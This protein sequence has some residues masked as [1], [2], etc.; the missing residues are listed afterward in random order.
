MAS[1]AFLALLCFAG[2]SSGL[3]L[4]IEGRRT[5][6][7]LLRRGNIDGTAALSNNA[8]ISYYTNLTL[9]GEVFTALIDTGR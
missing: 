2:Y 4:R 1:M 7:E 3:Q 6:Y 5:R 8:D 9:G